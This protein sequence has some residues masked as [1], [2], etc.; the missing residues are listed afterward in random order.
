MFMYPHK[1]VYEHNLNQAIHYNCFRKNLLD[2]L[3]NEFNV[4][5]LEKGENHE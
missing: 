4:T 1:Y 5:K 3:S 2:N